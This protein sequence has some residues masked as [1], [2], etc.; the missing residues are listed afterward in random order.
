MDCHLWISW[1]IGFIALELKIYKPST[2]ITTLENMAANL[3]EA[4]QVV[5]AVTSQMVSQ[6]KPLNK[7][8]KAAGVP[9]SRIMEMASACQAIPRGY[10]KKALA[11]SV[12]NTNPPWMTWQCGRSTFP[13]PSPQ[14]RS[15][16]YPPAVNTTSGLTP[17]RSLP[18]KVNVTTGSPHSQNDSPTTGLGLSLE[19][20]P[21]VTGV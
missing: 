15:S 11:I 21:S 4:N 16:T 7:A 10:T 17:S 12:R 2:Y 13:H 3:D 9:T 18:S 14:W 8:L 19:A 1:A 6:Y 20:G 5:E